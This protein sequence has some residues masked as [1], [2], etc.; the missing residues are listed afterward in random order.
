MQNA[1]DVLIL[2]MKIY[3]QIYGLN[4]RNRMLSLL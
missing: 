4:I 3:V 1:I 2:D